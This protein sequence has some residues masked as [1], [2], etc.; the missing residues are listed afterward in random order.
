MLRKKLK[1]HGAPGSTGIGHTRW[2]T[3]GPATET[4]AHPHVSGD[5]AVV[6]NG[7]I[8]NF[9]ELRAELEADDFTFV[10]QT[11]TESVP[12][13]VAKYLNQGM[14]PR[15]A[16]MTAIRRLTGAF[17]LCILFRGNEQFM[18][19]ARKGSPV[20]IGH[21]DGEMFV[22]S[23]AVALAPLTNRIQYLDDG[24]IAFVTKSGAE[25]VDLD[26]E[27]VTRNIKTVS[28]GDLTSDKGNNRHFMGKEICEQPEVIGAT[29]RQYLDLDHKVVLPPLPIDAK[30]ITSI[31]AVA[32]GTSAIA[33]HV[34]QYWFQQ[35][36]KVPFVVDIASEFVYRDTPLLPGTLGLVVS[37]SGE[38]ADTLSAVRVMQAAGVPVVS[39]VNVAESTIARET[40]ALYT[41]A[42]FER[43]VASTK[44]FATQLTT[45][46]CLVI[47][48]AR[49][50]GVIDAAR[51]RE[52]TEALDH[53][54]TLVQQ[55]LMMR[56][57][58][59]AIA[60][61]LVD[62]PSA[63]FLG[64]G[65]SYPLALEGALKLKEIS[66]IHAEGYAAGELKHGPI[67]LI[68]HH[69]PVVV[70][71]PSGEHFEK[72][73]SNVQEVCARGGKII[74]LS[75]Q[76]G[77]EHLAGCV[78]KSVILPKAHP[79]VVPMLYMPVLQLLAYYTAVLKGTD[80]DQP[81]NLAK[82]VTVE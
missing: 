75:D 62:A 23:D 76:Q 15:D 13:L 43:S 55:V 34:A 1:R 36:A 25:I 66:Y 26:G 57:D 38:T 70:I 72:V 71:A 28:L 3:H 74:L 20:V 80:V 7:I 30:N 51:E 12:H 79:L 50:R 9:R 31:C 60:E 16:A 21:G 67:A 42:G 52:L 44:A 61:E 78:W 46:A 5:V 48:I 22:G 68:D 69:M 14:G 53:I 45:L 65:T 4:N 37:Q 6:H 59:R 39:V 64:R 81:R 27:P 58:I 47:G 56:A 35:I 63:L 41:R 24:D 11:D 29:L 32:C 19:V 17:A 10:S 8:E 54:P 77:Y 18:V 40:I 82:S 33:L 2:A 73:A 49:A